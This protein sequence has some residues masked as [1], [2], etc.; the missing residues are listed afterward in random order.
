MK[1]QQLWEQVGWNIDFCESKEM[2]GERTGS[3]GDLVR[4][5]EGLDSISED[6]FYRVTALSLREALTLV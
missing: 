5:L 3:A 2:G 4:L 1:S 6:K